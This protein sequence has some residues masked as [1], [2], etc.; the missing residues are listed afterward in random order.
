MLSSSSAAARAVFRSPA[1]IAISTCAGRRRSRASGSWTS[2]SGAPDTRD[3]GVDL[4]L[5]EAEEGETGLRIA[6]QLVR[7]RV[8]LLGT[9]EVAALTTDLADLVVAASR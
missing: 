5:G 1:A 6:P 2:P 4:A 9:R 8:R 7:R 3:R